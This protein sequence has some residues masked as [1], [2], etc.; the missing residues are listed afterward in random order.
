MCTAGWPGRSDSERRSAER[1]YGEAFT[2][3]APAREQVRAL[4]LAFRHLLR[5]RDRAAFDG[6]GSPPP[7]AVCC[8]GLPRGP[9]TR[10]PPTEAAVGQPWNSLASAGPLEV[11][12][13]RRMSM[14][15]E[16]PLGDRA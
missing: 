1:A 5:E 12:E 7:R 4:G 3:I 14:R 15:C 10:G 16:R 11:K 6:L 2:G 9:R 13:S 8:M